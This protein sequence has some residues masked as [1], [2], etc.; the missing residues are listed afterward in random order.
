MDSTITARVTIIEQR[1]IAA[2]AGKYA[3]GIDLGGTTVKEGLFNEKE[4]PT[5]TEE[6]GKNILPDIAK[7]LKD[8]IKEKKLDPSDILGI[9][10][11]V[12]GP[13]LDGGI[14]N[15]CVNL[16]WGVVNVPQEL[17][18]MLGGIKVEAVND[19]NAA[20]LGEAAAADLR[21]C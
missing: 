9:G 12:P 21:A 4:I 17:S 7:S 19:A 20:A 16:G 15:N 3:F 8:K 2:M 5:R 14:V 18:G 11:D 13:V 1:R 6:N 10:I